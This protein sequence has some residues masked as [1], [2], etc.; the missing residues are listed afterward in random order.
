MHV[1]SPERLALTGA[2]GALG[3]AF[4]EQLLQRHPRLEA[5]LLVRRASAAFRSEIFQ[6]WLKAQG[7]R[8]RLVDGD[9]RA[10]PEEFLRAA[11]ESDGGLW[12]FAALTALSADNAPLNAEIDAV[13]REAT[14]RLLEALRRA[15]GR[16]PLYHISTAY[17]A[18]DRAGK[19]LES[20]GD[21]GQA[22]R[23]PYE[24]SK[25]AA[26]TAVRRA[27]AAGLPGLIYRPSVV[28][29]NHGGTGG[30]KMVD[31]CAYAV[32]LAI[33]RGEPFVF[34]LPDAASLNLVHS[35]WVVA[36]MEDLARMPSGPGVTYHLTAPRATGFR[37]IA[38][39][40]ERMAPGLK[41][42]FEPGLA[43]AELPSA[44]RLF[45]KAVAELRP[46]FESGVHFDRTHVDRDLSAGLK[47][48]PLDL[49]AFVQARLQTEMKR[50]M[51]RGR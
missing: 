1:Y 40:V 34:R 43:R 2:T 49:E 36:A 13:N 29:D 46:Y 4:L 35:D 32:A 37:D 33:R 12:H 47:Q 22:C 24:A 27:F 19:V 17:T 11:A 7:D 25:L 41:L 26:E 14:E 9:V 50:A 5:V 38:R 18:G 39:I 3:F 51:A 6:G 15:G 20:E 16:A 44:S 48:Q 42:A 23:N 45:D 30:I 28:V 21:L 8:V 31:A 10:L